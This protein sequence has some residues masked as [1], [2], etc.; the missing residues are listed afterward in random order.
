MAT[1]N[2]RL[3]SGTLGDSN[4]TLYTAPAGAGAIAII[5]SVA[6]C[7]KTTDP[8]TVTLELDGKYVIHEH[9]LAA[10]D[11]LIYEHL[12][13]IIEAGELIEGLASAAASV[14]YCICGKEIT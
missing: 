12:D 5:K 14:D 1:T 9:A 10:H 11:S 7:N 2:K 8:V 6:L 13:Q 3:C 4:A